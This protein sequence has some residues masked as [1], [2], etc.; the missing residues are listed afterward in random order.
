MLKLLNSPHL[1]LLTR[2]TFLLIKAKPSSILSYECR[3]GKYLIVA[4]F[5]SQFCLPFILVGKF[6][7]KKNDN[8]QFSKLF[9][10]LWRAFKTTFS[11]IEATKIPLKFI[12]LSITFMSNT[13]PCTKRR[14]PL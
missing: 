10:H 12:K 2:I 5:S 14:T 8:I 11:V 13:I 3:N 6:P 7:S 9:L 4:T 1:F